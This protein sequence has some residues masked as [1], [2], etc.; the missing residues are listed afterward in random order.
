MDNP[1]F[2]VR[3]MHAQYGRQLVY[4]R[5]LQYG[6]N[7]IKAQRLARYRRALDEARPGLFM[8]PPPQRRKIMVEWVA[9]ELFENLLFTG[10]KTPVL[11]AV[12]EELE[13]HCGL[14]VSFRYPP[15]AAG[16]SVFKRTQ[17]GLI[18][19]RDQEKTDIL[20]KVWWIIMKK[21]DETML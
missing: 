7:L 14:P 4:G 11:A 8:P 19:V 3:H 13:K 16:V 1:P 21:V 17:D 15:G 18:E 5:Q 10:S 12:H 20:F 6:R 2:Y 9:R